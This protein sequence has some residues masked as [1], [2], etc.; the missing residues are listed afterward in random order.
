MVAKSAFDRIPDLQFTLFTITAY[1]L[2]G[3]NI[4]EHDG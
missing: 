4:V 1:G 3:Y 2:G